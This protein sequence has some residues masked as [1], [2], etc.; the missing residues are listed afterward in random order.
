MQIEPETAEF[1][2]KLS[3]GYRFTTSDLA[4]PSVN[5]AYGSYYL[6]YLLDHYDGNEMLAV[7]AYNAGLA[8][9]DRWVAKARAEGGQLTVDR[10]PVLG[11]ARV[12]AARARSAEEIPRDV[13][14]A[15][16]AELIPASLDTLATVGGAMPDFRLDSAFTPTADQPK[17]IAA[18]AAGDRAG[19]ALSDAAGGDGHGQDD[20]DGGRD[21][22]GAAPDARDRPQQDA[23]GAAVQRVQDVLPGQ[24]GRVLRLLLRLLPARGIRA[25]PGSVHRE[26]L[27]D[28]PGGRPAAP[29]GHGG[30]VRAQGRDRGG[31]GVVHLRAGLAGD[32]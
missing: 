13:C 5:V 19:R 10:D 14:Q 15:A 29:R 3:G 24:R 16:R 25:E 27:R 8:N 11:D 32:V 7:A 9:V 26:G 17:A 30:G 28:Q 12:R 31:L 4:T 1:L 21:R 20:D 18:M 22:G 23:R 6:R 2:A